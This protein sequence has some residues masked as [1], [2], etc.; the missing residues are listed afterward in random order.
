MAWLMMLGELSV[1]MM[2]STSLSRVIVCPVICLLL[3]SRREGCKG[4]RLTLG[5]PVLLRRRHPMFV[6][7]ILCCTRHPP[8]RYFFIGSTSCLWT[9]WR[10]VC[11]TR[12]MRPV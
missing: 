7:R 9:I 5:T 4:F 11:T 1:L 6:L 3:P 8:S 12:C 2:L 10:R